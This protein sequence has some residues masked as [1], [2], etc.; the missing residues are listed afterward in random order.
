[1]KKIYAIFILA[2]AF[3]LVMSVGVFAVKVNGPSAVNGLNHKGEASQL[4]LYEK[5]ADWNVVEDGAWGKMTFSDNYFVFNGHGLE[6]NTEYTLIRY[7]DP[8][9]GY[10]ISCLDS[11]IANE[12]DN[13]HLSGKFLD[14]G[15][16]VWLVLS[17]DVDCENGMVGWN[18]TEYLFEYNSINGDSESASYTKYHGKGIYSTTHIVR[19]D[20]ARPNKPQK[21]DKTS[22]GPACYKLMG[23]KWAN[24]P[25]YVAQSQDLLGIAGTSIGTW[26]ASTGFGLLGSGSVD[27]SAGFEEVMD[28]K[29]S[30]SEGD[31]PTDGVIAVTRTWYNIYTNEIIEY[32]IMFDTDFTWGDAT[33]MSGVMDLQNI[34]THEIG[35]AFGLLDLYQKPCSDVTMFGYSSYGDVSKRDLAPQDITGLQLIYGA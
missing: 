31:Y 28:G 19:K 27:A 23:V 10:P 34:A 14:G 9:N 4:Y 17:S 25:D 35:H 30:Y 18:P 24:T 12:D 20:Y 8:W 6:Q 29:N 26:D 2:T 22:G 1:M 32:D 11:G 13:L 15:A 5:D 21:P 33:T 16:K 3:M 7:T